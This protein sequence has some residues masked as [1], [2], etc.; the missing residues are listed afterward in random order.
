MLLGR[1]HRHLSLP[2]FYLG[3]FYCYFCFVVI[4]IGKRVDDSIRPL[5]PNQVIPNAPAN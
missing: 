5:P 2:A 1:A 3:H 4:I